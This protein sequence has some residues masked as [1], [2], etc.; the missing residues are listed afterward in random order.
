MGD[1]RNFCLVLIMILS[2]VF[3]VMGFWDLLKGRQPNESE[4]ATISRQ[5]RGIGY[6]LLSQVILVIGVIF[7]YGITGG[8]AEFNSWFGN[9]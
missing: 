2:V 8:K 6:L 3:L 5:I 9:M 1:G 7:C 4:T